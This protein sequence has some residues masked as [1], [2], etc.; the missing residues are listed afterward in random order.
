MWSHIIYDFQFIHILFS[1]IPNKGWRPKPEENFYENCE[2]KDWIILVDTPAYICT[3]LTL[4]WVFYDKNGCVV[5]AWSLMNQ[6]YIGFIG[7]PG[8]YIHKAY[9]NHQQRY[10]GICW[11]SVTFPCEIRATTPICHA[12]SGILNGDLVSA[13]VLQLQQLHLL[14][15]IARRAAAGA[16]ST[17]IT[18]VASHLLQL[19][20]CSRNAHVQ[21]RA[22]ELR[23]HQQLS[24]LSYLISA[25][26]VKMPSY[27]KARA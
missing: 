27:N 14:S 25:A 10:C 8:M 16:P 6:F 24:P 12:R 23:G 21:L 19:I 4:F 13:T 2:R 20:S 5:L 17:C 26:Y 18:S 15:A 1:Y 11:S 3:Q 22:C 9:P 7:W